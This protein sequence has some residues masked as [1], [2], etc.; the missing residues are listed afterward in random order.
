L[1]YKPFLSFRFETETFTPDNGD[2]RRLG[3][4]IASDARIE[5]SGYD[6]I[7]FG[8]NTFGEEMVSGTRYHWISDGGIV[9]I[10]Y[11]PRSGIFELSFQVA[12]PV[13]SDVHAL[14]IRLGDGSI[15]FE[16][17][18]ADDF[19]NYRVQISEDDVK[20]NGRFVVNN[21]SSRYSESTGY[22]LDIGM[23]EDDIGQFDTSGFVQA[24]CGG[25]MLIRRDILGKAGIFDDYF[26]AYYE[27]TDFCWRMNT[28]G[29]TL[30]FEPKSVVYHIHTG[31]SKEWS[32]FFRYHT[33]R[34]RL[35]MLIK[36]ASI[37]SATREL[38]LFLIHSC[39]V[40]TLASKMTIM[41]IVAWLDVVFHMP[42]LL[43][44]R[45]KKT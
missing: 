22:G 31:T 23:G 42:Y 4:R 12:A 7:L 28:V 36:N 2:S 18:I 43:V 32:P 9:K 45:F 27:D 20:R 34:N 33:D 6:K 21:A 37:Q 14:R 26:F 10:P 25:C 29:R 17:N 39:G 30:Y 11:D 3:V 19:R 13:G 24:L 5:S 35:A 41:R 1:F 8:Q 38:V 16:R 44:R 15:V 40:K